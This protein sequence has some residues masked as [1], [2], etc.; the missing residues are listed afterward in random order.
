VNA[1]GAVFDRDGR[2]VR[3][4]L[5]RAT[6][7]RSGLVEALERRLPQ[8]IPGNTTLTAVLTNQRLDRREL[9]QLAAQ[10][11]SSLA[12]AIQPF[13]A[14]VDGDVLYAV[15]TGEAD[16]AA[17]PATSLG[18]LASELAWDAVLASVLDN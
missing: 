8:T 15:T 2:V 18:V 13:H 11:H 17:L 3:G 12:R 16:N 6:G 4:H 14:L 10:V 1:F 5:D 7:T 9:R